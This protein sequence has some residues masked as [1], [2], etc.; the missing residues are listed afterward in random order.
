[1]ITQETSKGKTDVSSSPLSL[2]KIS[3]PNPNFSTLSK[4]VDIRFDQEIGRHGVATRRIRAGEL[5]LVQE[6]GVWGFPPFEE[7]KFTPC[8]GVGGFGGSPPFEEAT[9]T[10]FSSDKIR[11]KILN[12]GYGVACRAL[13]NLSP[14]SARILSAAITIFGL[15]GAG[16]NALAPRRG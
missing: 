9:S 15:P 2:P 4:A 7:A 11:A 16:S 5:L 14:K 1:M 3:S 13:H 6:W 12:L 8:A 10:P